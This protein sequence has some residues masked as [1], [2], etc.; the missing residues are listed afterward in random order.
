MSASTVGAGGTVTVGVHLTNAVSDVLS[1]AICYALPDGSPAPG[2]QGPQ[3]GP[4]RIA[5]SLVS[6]TSRDGI[7]QGLIAVPPAAAAGLWTVHFLMVDARD[8]FSQFFAPNPLFAGGNF[9][10]IGGSDTTPPTIF[11]PTI[12]PS[13]VALGGTV[14]ISARITDASGVA[15][16]SIQTL[17]NTASTVCCVPLTLASGTPQDGLWQINLIPSA[18]GNYDLTLVA[19]QDAAGNFGQIGP[20]SLGSFTVTGTTG[21]P[22]TIT[23]P[24]GV[25]V[26]ATSPAG[27]SLVAAP[28]IVSGGVPPYQVIAPLPGPY[29][30]GQ[31]TL[32]YSATDA[33]GATVE[34][35]TFI[36]VLDTTPPTITCPAP[37]TVD[38]GPNGTAVVTYTATATD[39]AGATFVI[40][41]IQPGSVFA[42]GTTR[43]TATASDVS[44]N[45]S[46]CSFNVTVRPVVTTLTVNNSTGD[47]NDSATLSGTLQNSSGNPIVG[48][49]VT[50]TVSG[51]SCSGV[52]DATGSG[53]CAITPNEAAGSYTITGSYA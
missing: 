25:F 53:S 16:A 36:R 49:T 15:A 34:C 28:P 3:I 33:A 39:I 32:V 11:P 23:C 40:Y 14:T 1:A 21:A 51:Q 41:S 7:W 52:T 30:M 4:E 43:V 37:I 27:A 19:A 10:V 45:K 22:L 9:T 5:L 35:T 18:P 2:C 44:G 17:P 8:G 20:P 42:I 31:T 47:F 46:S 38:A 12:S 6:G 50:F 29:P 24:P 13:T 48:A 26:E